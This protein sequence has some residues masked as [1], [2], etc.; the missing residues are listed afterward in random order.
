MRLVFISS[1]TAITPLRTISVMTGSA[2]TFRARFFVVFAMTMSSTG[3]AMRRSLPL[4]RNIGRLDDLGP[5]FR[6][7][8]DELFE[9]GG[10]HRLRYAAKIDK[11]RLDL[12]IGKRRVYLLIQSVD[13]IGGRIFGRA[14]AL[15]GA[16]LESRHG[17]SH[18]RD[19]RQ[20]LRARHAG[21]GQRAHRTRFDGADRLRQWAEHDLHLP[22]NQVGEP[23][24]TAAIR[25]VNHVDAGHHLEKLAADMGRAAAAARR[26]A[27][28]AWIRLGVS[29]EFGNRLRWY[30]RIDLHDQGKV[31]DHRDGNDIA[32]EIEV[33]I[34]V[35]R[36]VGGDRL[37]DQEK[38]VA[39]RRGT[40]GGF[41]P[42]IR[43]RA[44]PVLDDEWL[45]EA[46]R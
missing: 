26:H 4:Q 24:R 1:V 10:R 3:S 36:G 7:V 17:L 28:L 13:N 22:G 9:V 2:F 37:G 35:E 34:L 23:G 44:G 38:R 27:D 39:V 14:D 41:D 45:V 42:D 5:F 12:R 29:Y 8:D 16:G 46:L 18:G 19:I 40:H 21:H 20:R 31:A 30:R 33:E 43:S 32:N 6:L 15:P 25:H 11:S